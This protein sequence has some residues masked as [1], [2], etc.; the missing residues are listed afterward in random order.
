LPVTESPVAFEAREYDLVLFGAT[1]FTGTLAAEYLAKNYG[2]TI[3]WAIAGRNMDKLSKLRE[4]LVALDPA[5]SELPLLEAAASDVNNL[6]KVVRQTRVVLS[7]VG[8]FAR[9]GTPL[10]AVCASEGV[11]YCDITGEIAWCREMIDRYDDVAC[12]SGAKIVHCCGHD[13]VPWDLL[14]QYLAE[15]IVTAGKPNETITKVS[16]Y[17]EIRSAPSGGTIETLFNSLETPHVHKS[18]LGYDPLLKASDGTTSTAGQ[19]VEGKLH[20]YLPGYSSEFGRYTGA[21]VMSA[22]NVNAIKRSNAVCKYAPSTDKFVYQE[23]RAFP[24][25]MAVFIDFMYMVFFAMAFVLPPLK[26]LIRGCCL[27]KPGQGPS[28]ESMEAGCLKITGFATGSEG[29]RGKASF[30][31]PTDPGYKD[32]ARMLVEAGLALALEGDKVRAPGGVWMPACCQ[33]PVLLERLLNTGSSISEFEVLAAGSG[34][35]SI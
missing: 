18:S 33:G 20:G 13:C 35:G 10:V 14:T 8:P 11:S 29:T 17:D 9:H 12:K 32:T 2:N 15:G 16:I 31:F 26:W 25:F 30:W 24:G 3:R 23:A 5:M 22:V 4:Q 19:G 21:F 28:A 27:P 7:T 34:T 1:G 6:R